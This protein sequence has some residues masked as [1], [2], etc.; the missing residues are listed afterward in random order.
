ML[1]RLGIDRTTM[2]KATFLTAGAL[3][4]AYALWSM[5]A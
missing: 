5:S 4:F 2:K 3:A 1:A